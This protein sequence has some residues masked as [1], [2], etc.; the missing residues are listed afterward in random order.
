MLLGA[1]AAA[2]AASPAHSVSTARQASS[3]SGNNVV[4]SIV[5]SAAAISH[6]AAVEVTFSTSEA[7]MEAV[8]AAA[9]A[10]TRNPF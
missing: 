5:G 9:A 1:T 7:N 6:A 8:A 3:I 4:E 2:T 10:E